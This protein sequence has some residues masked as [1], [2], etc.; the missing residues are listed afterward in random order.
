MSVKASIPTKMIKTFLLGGALVGASLSLVACGKTV[1]TEAKYPSGYDRSETGGDIYG[2][3]QSVFGDGGLKLFGGRS[4]EAQDQSGIGVNGFLWRAALDT[5]SFMPM[6]SADPFG[7]T[8]LTDWYS[9]PESPD[10]RFKL[11]VLILGRELRSD[12][13]KVKVFRQKLEGGA[14]KDAESDNAMGSQLENA[15]LRRARELRIAHL[16]KQ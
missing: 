12:G 15:I 7:G 14:W 11:N 8:I 9:A 2:K 10:E 6:A 5:V 4:D 3:R 16:D 13:V 1:E